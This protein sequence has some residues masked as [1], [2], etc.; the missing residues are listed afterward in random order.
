MSRNRTVRI[1]VSVLALVLLAVFIIVPQ[2]RSAA[3]EAT[4]LGAIHRGWLLLGVAAEALS[5]L[6]YARLTQVTLH[7]ARLP[8]GTAFAIDLATFS[9]SH[10]VPAGSLVGAGLGVGLFVRSGVEPSRA[11]AGKA[12]QSAASAVALNVLFALALIATIPRRDD[13]WFWAAAAGIVVLFLA[14]CALVVRVLLHRP[15]GFADRLGRIGRRLPRVGEAAGRRLADTVHGT[16]QQVVTHGADRRAVLL[17][18]TLNWVLDAA[19]LW[20]CV[21]AFDHSLGLIGLFATY[22]L[23]QVFAAIPVTPGGLGV[24]EG[25]V[26]PALMSFHTPHAAAVFGMTAWRL[27]NFWAPIPLGAATLLLLRHRSAVDPQP[28]VTEPAGDQPVTVA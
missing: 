6:A 16:V 10:I 13:S 8:F 26:V 28:D 2:L 5:L 4:T 18:A 15:D 22:G 17:W 12:V 14:G 21:R 24:V 20:C 23:A 3:S 25:I 27:L 11:I 1:A 19:A 7:P 9:V